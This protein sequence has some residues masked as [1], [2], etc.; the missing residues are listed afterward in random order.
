MVTI[1]EKN[2]KARLYKYLSC[3]VEDSVTIQFLGTCKEIAKKIEKGEKLSRFSTMFY[4]NH[5]S[6]IEKFIH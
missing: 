5:K 1:Q 6:E 3:P 2:E 4:E